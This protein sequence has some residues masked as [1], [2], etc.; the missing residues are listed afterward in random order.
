MKYI[1]II[2]LFI[3]ASC[4]NEILSPNYKPQLFHANL[5]ALNKIEINYENDGNHAL[6]LNIEKDQSLISYSPKKGICIAE[7][8]FSNQELFFNNI[9]N[10]IGPFKLAG[11]DLKIIQGKSNVRKDGSIFLGTYKNTKNEEVEL[12]IILVKYQ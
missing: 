1:F 8:V 9:N 11:N 12:T 6:K 7:L 10:K 5:V 2:L 4:E 3:V